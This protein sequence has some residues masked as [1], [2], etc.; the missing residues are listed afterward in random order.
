MA[1]I[2][3]R[4]KGIIPPPIDRNSE[5]F[6]DGLESEEIR[7]PRCNSCGNTWFPPTPGC[8]F[9]GSTDYE[10]VAT[11]PTGRIYSWVVVYRSLHPEFA[12]ELPYVVATVTLDDGPRLFAR[13]FDIEVDQI[14][15]DQPVVAD[16]YEVGEQRLLGFVPLQGSDGE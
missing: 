7:L 9:C 10:V 14:E 11:R 8:P 5:G 1:E 4:Q 2:A 6:W 3:Q 12:D 13:L 15:A 16:F